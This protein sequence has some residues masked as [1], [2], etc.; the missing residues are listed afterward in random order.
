MG[1]GRAIQRLMQARRMNKRIRAAA[2]TELAAVREGEIVRVTG[3]A[4][5]LG[6]ALEAP[7]SL[8]ACVYYGVVV[9]AW[10]QLGNVRVLGHEDERL[11]FTLVDGE[12]R[13]VVDPKIATVSSAYD[14]VTRWRPRAPAPD[15]VEA[16]L[17]RLGL[18]RHLWMGTSVVEL[19]EAVLELD[20][21]ISVVG[22][23]E[24]EPDPTA[25]PVGGYRDGSLATRLRFA[26]SSRDPLLLSDDPSTL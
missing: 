1:V 25:T 3:T 13:A 4:R 16:L 18:A 7:L 9:H 22:A 20:E 8:R 5:P 10:D 23:A 19:S 24:R 17:A 2:R 11:P 14:H 6:A 21:A 26:G 15:A 12:A